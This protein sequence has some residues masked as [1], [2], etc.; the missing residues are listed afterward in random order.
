[1]PIMKSSHLCSGSSA[2]FFILCSFCPAAAAACLS[3]DLFTVPPR[4]AAVI[5]GSLHRIRHFLIFPLDSGV[6]FAYYKS[7]TFV[8]ITRRD[9]QKS[10]S[11]K[12]R[13]RNRT[14][15]IGFSGG[16]RRLLWCGC[17]SGSESY[18]YI[19]KRWWNNLNLWSFRWIC[20]QD[21]WWKICWK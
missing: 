16:G 6:R 7:R 21:I 18:N 19:F 17:Y 2:S 20:M 8:R 9:I 11:V 5:Q 15:R 10:R 13:I 4:R 14:G 3:S 1:M 12:R